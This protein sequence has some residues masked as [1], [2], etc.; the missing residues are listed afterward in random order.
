MI[1]VEMYKRAYELGKIDAANNNYQCWQTSCLDVAYLLGHNGK[2]LNFDDVVKC[3]RAGKAPKG[4]IS[5]NY[6]DQSSEN[7]LSVL[8]VIGE[9]EVGSSV[10]FAERKEVEVE[11]IR[12][13]YKGSDG[14][15]LILPL[16]IEQYD[17]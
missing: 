3:V 13:P 9:E 14:E 1:T 11:G 6:R 12:L 8:N 16:N 7:G 10:W 5:Y 17:F 15:T 2:E 4:G